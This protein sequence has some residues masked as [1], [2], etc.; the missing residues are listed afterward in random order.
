ML[1]ALLHINGAKLQLPIFTSSN[2]LHR[3]S[4]SS[5]YRPMRVLASNNQSYWTSINESI[6]AHLRQAIRI[7]EPLV[8]FE[9]L[10][11]LTF[12]APRTTAPA[13]CVAACELVGGHRNQAIATAAA[14]HLMHAATYAHD[15]LLSAH[16]PVR[17]Q[18]PPG[19]LPEYSTTHRGY[20]LPVEL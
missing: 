6:E 10:H 13:L 4:S 16:G 3:P 17:R 15:H 12:S 19:L 8:V 2:N 18:G 1:K 9:P 7:R 14:L 20:Y 11:Q 5:S